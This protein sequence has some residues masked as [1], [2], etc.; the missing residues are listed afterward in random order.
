MEEKPEIREKYQQV[1]SSIPKETLVYI[2]ESGIEMTIYA[3]IDDRAK[4]ELMLRAKRV[5]NIT[6]V[7][8][9]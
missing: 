6:S 7:Q 8:I 1:I 3:R 9:L 2:D 4:K 5:V